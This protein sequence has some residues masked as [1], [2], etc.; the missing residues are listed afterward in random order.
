MQVSNYC[1]SSDN[2]PISDQVTSGITANPSLF[3]VGCTFFNANSKSI[4]SILIY[5]SVGV[6]III[7]DNLRT[8]STDAS[9]H[10]AFKSDAT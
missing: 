6:S 4:V 7:S 5:S 8:A 3:A 2:D 10:K 9:L 1:L